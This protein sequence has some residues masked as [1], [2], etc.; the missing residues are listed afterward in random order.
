MQVPGAQEPSKGEFVMRLGVSG[1]WGILSPPSRF[2]HIDQTNDA[3][4]FEEYAGVSWGLGEAGLSDLVLE[5]K[6]TFFQ[7]ARESVGGATVHSSDQ[8]SIL[9][10]RLSG[11]FIHLPKFRLGTWIQSD[12][13]FGM[14]KRKFVKPGVNYIGGGLSASGELRDNVYLSQAVFLGSGLFSPRT[15]NLN[16][17]SNTLPSFN[18]GRLFFDFDSTF[19]TGFSVEADLSSRTDASYASSAIADGKIQNLVFV[20]PF[21]VDIPVSDK[22]SLRAAY[23]AK[24]AGKSSRGS[25]FFN[26]ELAYKF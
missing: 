23:A 14:N 15:K 10:L 25:Q 17:I 3:R 13:P 7:S 2:K 4:L 16:L 12:I 8:G 11:D 19:T 24:W 5:S 20:T 1:L 21:I 18:W 26:T 22:M 6:F 9:A